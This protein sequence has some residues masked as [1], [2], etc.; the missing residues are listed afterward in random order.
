MMKEGN[1]DAPCGG[2]RGRDE[3]HEDYKPEEQKKSRADCFYSCLLALE[4]PDL[5]EDF[6]YDIDEERVYNLM[7]E[8]MEEIGIEAS[9]PL[10]P[11]CEASR[12]LAC[13]GNTTYSSC[14]SATSSTNCSSKVADACGSADLMKMEAA[15]SVAKNSEWKDYELTRSVGDYYGKEDFVEVRSKRSVLV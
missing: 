13:L 6:V 3:A 12:P 5:E 1:E 9:P 4:S 11:P 7:K 2:K 10:P 8:L 14:N 15:K